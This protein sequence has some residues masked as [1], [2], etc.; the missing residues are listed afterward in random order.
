KIEG[1][2]SDLHEVYEDDIMEG[3]V[4]EGSALPVPHDYFQF[5]RN[6]QTVNDGQIEG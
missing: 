5:A 4:H 1:E 3:Y 6:F 2:K